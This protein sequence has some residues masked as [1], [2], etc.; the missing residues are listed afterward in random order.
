MRKRGR[1]GRGRKEVQKHALFRPAR[2]QAKGSSGP[3]ERIYGE[4]CGLE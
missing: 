3:R 2:P 1:D 4:G